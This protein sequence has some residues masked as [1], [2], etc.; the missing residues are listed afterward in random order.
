MPCVNLVR[1]FAT[2]PTRVIFIAQD[3][4]VKVGGKILTAEVQVPAEELMEGPRGFRVNVID[5]DASTGA[6]YQPAD[7]RTGK[8]GIYRDPYSLENRKRKKD[9]RRRDAELVGDP[10]F[11]AQNVYAIVMRTLARFE[12]A[13]GRRVA[14][15]SDGHQIHIA[16][17]AFAE[18]NAFIRERTG[19]S[20]LGTSPANAASPFSLAWRT[21]SSHTRPRTLF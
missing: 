3:P 20:S 7:L 17:H 10:K 18:A 15:G 11:H 19:A 21:M 4:S 12:F 8:D 2:Y 5:Y 13:L 1:H 9:G 14:C 16:P 6:L